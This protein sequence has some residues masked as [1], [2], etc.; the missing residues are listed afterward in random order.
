MSDAI[1]FFKK[2]VETQGVACSTVNDGHV[3]MFKRSFLQ[4]LIDK[5]LDKEELVIFIKRPDFKD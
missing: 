1:D 5:N 4:D 2:L 3:L